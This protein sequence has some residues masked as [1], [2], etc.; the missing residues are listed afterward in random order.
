MAE[1]ISN[2]KPGDAKKIEPLDVTEIKKFL[3]QEIKGQD[4]AVEAWAHILQRAL[5]GTPKL[6]KGPLAIIT[7]IG[8]SGV[9]KTEIAIQAA[10]FLATQAQIGQSLG[11]SKEQPSLLRID[12]GEYVREHEVSKI[13]GSPPGYIGGDITPRLAQSEVNQYAIHLDN[14]RKVTILVFD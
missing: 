11:P 4:E 14:R 3:E 6:R 10:R 8:P 12:C 5:I 1:L 2:F 13:L 9:G 7:E